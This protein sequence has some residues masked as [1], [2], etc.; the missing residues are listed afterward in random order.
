[1]QFHNF[2]PTE[3]L[4]NLK[5]ELLRYEALYKENIDEY[6]DL[7]DA[8]EGNEP[9]LELFDNCLN[10]YS[11]E[12]DSLSSKYAEDFSDRVLHDRQL[13]FYISQ[14]LFEIGFNG[15]TGSGP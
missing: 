11:S 12:F 4:S 1:M 13:C 14:L 6:C 3:C 10:V 7:L 5:A 8:D 9:L 15:D 2:K